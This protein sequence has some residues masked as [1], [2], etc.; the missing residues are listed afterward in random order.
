MSSRLGHRRLWLFTPYLKPIFYILCD[1]YILVLAVV[2]IERITN[3]KDLNL[4]QTRGEVTAH[5]DIDC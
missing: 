3:C 2:V 4:L 5:V 1:L